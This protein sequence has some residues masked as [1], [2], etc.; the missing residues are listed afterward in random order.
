MK[1]RIGNVLAEGDRVLIT[2]PE[3]STFGFVAKL[4]E[5]GLYAI[6]GGTTQQP[7]SILVSCVI[8]IPVDP[9]MGQTPHLVKV[10]DPDK[11]DQLIHEDRIH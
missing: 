8:A 10:W 4:E 9:M 2:L 5:G 11:H 3:S 7:G 6:K 1:D